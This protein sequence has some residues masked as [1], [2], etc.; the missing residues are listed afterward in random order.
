MCTADHL[1]SCLGESKVPDL[2]LLDEV[3]DC[4]RH[5]FDRHIGI[6]AMLIKEIDHISPEAFKRSMGYFFDVLGTAIQARRLAIRADLPSELGSDYHFVA[7]RSQGFTHKFFI[8]VRS[9]DF[10][11]I[12]ESYAALEGVPNH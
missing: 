1:H 9:V 11:C 10:G 8:C 7:K 12:K 2:A 5:V 6:Y 3:L 4:P